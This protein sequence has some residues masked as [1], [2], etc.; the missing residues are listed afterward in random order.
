MR[1]LNLAAIVTVLAVAIAAPAL[2]DKGGNPH[3]GGNSGAG[4]SGGSGSGQADPSCSAAPNPA[5]VGQSFVLSASG[6]PTADS[7]WLL[8]YPPSGDATVSQ[9]YVNADGSWSATEVAN[10]TGMWTYVFSGLMANN[11]Y[12]TVAS[13]TE[14]V[15]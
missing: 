11:R 10:Q 13:C 1:L 7:V 14:R 5:G 8:V 2:A 6:L 3:G 15:G 4:G 12:G 9:V